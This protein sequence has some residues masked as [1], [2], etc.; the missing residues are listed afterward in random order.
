MRSLDAII[1]SE[2]TEVVLVDDGSSDGTASALRVA[3]PSI[4]LV[5]GDGSLYWNRGMLLAWRKALDLEPDAV[6]WINDDVVFDAEQFS[7]LIEAFVDRQ[8]DRQP[9][10]ILTAACCDENGTLSYSGVDQNL[11][12]VNPKPD[13]WIELHAMNGNCVL[14]PKAVW[15]RI[16]LLDA[17]FRHAFGDYDYGLRARKSG[18][19]ILLMPGYVGTCSLHGELRWSDPAVPLSKRFKSYFS[20]TGLSPRD[21]LRF[22]FRHY[23]YIAFP[24]LAY[25]F[26]RMLFGIQK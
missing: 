13:R 7:K 18:I 17:G 26:I 15:E 9:P 10:A 12:K 1:A 3:Y 19:P 11:N 5:Q 4:I 16:G 25:T 22:K 23:G 24:I 8:I 14:V 6:I 21:F 20:P 2:H